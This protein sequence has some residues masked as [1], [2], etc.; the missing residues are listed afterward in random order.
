MITPGG[1]LVPDPKPEPSKETVRLVMT[2]RGD[3]SFESG[4]DDG[5]HRG[6]LRIS[7]GELDIYVKVTEQQAEKLFEMGIEEWT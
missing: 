1:L 4:C 3:I 5:Y 6:H 2:G 7:K